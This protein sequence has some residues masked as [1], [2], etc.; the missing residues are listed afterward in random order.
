MSRGVYAWG[1]ALALLLHAA[2]VCAAA[3]SGEAASFLRS[4]LS[5]KLLVA[6]F[7]ALMT[8]VIGYWLYRLNKKKDERRTITYT[9]KIDQSLRPFEGKLAAAEVRFRGKIVRNLHTA[10]CVLTNSG[11]RVVRQQELRFFF[12]DDAEVLEFAPD[13]TP[14][15]EWGYEAWPVGGDDP[16]SVR[17]KLIY[18]PPGASIT[19]GFVVAAED[20]VLVLHSRNDESDVVV[21]EK[22]SQVA[23]SEREAV[24]QFVFW[25]MIYLLL[26]PLFRLPLSGP[27]GDL[28]AWAVRLAVIGFIAPTVAPLAGIVGRLLVRERDAPGV[29]VS[30]QGSTVD[31]IYI[32]QA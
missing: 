20:P 15:R 22:S 11:N 30:V 6:L 19:L 8:A 5:E 2:P 10:R 17:I 4:D 26:P 25:G 12:G 24:R 3:G 23:T 31:K 29:N 9:A 21:V 7:S 14:E 18:F 16:A 13:A 28:A 32:D 1:A 27:F